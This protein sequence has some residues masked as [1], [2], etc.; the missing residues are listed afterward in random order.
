MTR[1][2]PVGVWLVARTPTHKAYPCRCRPT[3]RCD[4]NPAWGCPCTGR[5]DHL[6]TMPTHCCARRAAETDERTA[7]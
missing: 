6:D 1:R 5:T 4:P 3:R 2:G 7:A